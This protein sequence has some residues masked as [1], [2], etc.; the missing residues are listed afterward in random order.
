M[1]T[2]DF[3]FNYYRAVAAGGAESVPA[4]DDTSVV[5]DLPAQDSPS[6]KE[7]CGFTLLAS[8]SMDVEVGFWNATLPADTAWV[9]AATASLIAGT[10]LEV[11]FPYEGARIYVRK[12]S[13]TADVSNLYLG[14]AKFSP[15]TVNIGQVPIPAGASTAARQASS[16]LITPSAKTAPLSPAASECIVPGSTPCNVGVLVQAD[17]ANTG[18]V[19]VGG[20]AV[21]VGQGVQLRKGDSMFVRVTNAN[22]LYCVSTAAGDKLQLEVT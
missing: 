19:Y 17:L 12:T 22:L 9:V 6:A 8:Q 15:T 2:Q 5:W 1:T 4:V 7:Y 20:T 21:A 14:L 10:P 16:T 13:V 11:T 3:A 18:I